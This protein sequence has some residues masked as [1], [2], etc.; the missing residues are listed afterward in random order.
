MRETGVARKIAPRV[1]ELT[2]GSAP[3]GLS[4]ASPLMRAA[5][6]LRNGH[7]AGEAR[8]PRAVALLR[9]CRADRGAGPTGGT[10]AAS[11]RRRRR[12]SDRSVAGREQVIQGRRQ[13]LERGRTLPGGDG[14]RRPPR[15]DIDRGRPEQDF[16]L[17]RVGIQDAGEDRVLADDSDA[18]PGA[19]RGRG[20]GD[21]VR[22]HR[23]AVA[24]RARPRSRLGDE[25]ALGRGRRGGV[26]VSRRLRGALVVV[27]PITPA[28]TRPSAA[29]AATTATATAITAIRS[30]RVLPPGLR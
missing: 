11:A 26:M 30:A 24:G 16:V 29:A 19:P 3:P 9:W 28:F 7:G 17:G 12:K 5:A 14:H 20:D 13:G 10:T 15:T 27:D 25:G 4:T 22:R 21:L 8:H 23:D 18:D 1:P 6:P 2:S